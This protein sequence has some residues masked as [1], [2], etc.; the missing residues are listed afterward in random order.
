MLS[1]IFSGL[2]FSTTLLTSCKK[3]SNAIVTLSFSSPGT[4]ASLNFGD[5]IIV[6]GT[7]KSD[8]TIESVSVFLT[9]NQSFTI[10]PPA[11]VL[12]NKNPGTYNF[13]TS[14][15][16]E[17][18]YS[19]GG[20]YLLRAMV[21]TNNKDEVFNQSVQVNSI[22]R[23]TKKIF[24]ATGINSTIHLNVLEDSILNVLG[25]Y[26]G[27]FLNLHTDSR[28]QQ[29]YICTKE[30]IR[31]VNSNSFTSLFDI[32]PLALNAD[33]FIASSVYENNINVCRN[34]G[35]IIAYNATG[36]KSNETGENQFLRPLLSYV[37]DNYNYVSVE[38]SGAKKIA[39][40]FYPSGSARQELLIDFD[41]VGFQAIGNNQNLVIGNRN[42]HTVIYQYS[43][44]NNGIQLL[45][46][47]PAAS[48]TEIIN[49]NN[50]DLLLLTDQGLVKYDP[51]LNS[52]ITVHPGVFSHATLDEVSDIIYC[53]SA[54]NLVLIQG[55][56]F[57]EIQSIVT[58][59]PILDVSVLYSK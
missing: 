16:L 37:Y 59:E 35:N 27:N 15:I 30:K 1:I 21:N 4:G 49:L 10:C 3:E 12:A 33:S 23:V 6:S 42:G 38:K 19:P 28:N 29:T 17:N 22:P 47:L 7:V 57:A 52:T 24:V 25:T 54:N 53:S 20:N 41:I 11:Q 44:D 2:L 26:Q 13:S 48:T 56:S 40:F 36:F 18:N 51:D 8:F 5:T 9:N 50:S 58:A 31:A 39:V 55:N 45:K 46:D 43:L 32:S 14:Y 34:D